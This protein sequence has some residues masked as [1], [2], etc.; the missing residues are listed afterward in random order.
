MNKEDIIN[1]VTSDIFYNNYCEMKCNYRDIHKDLYQFII[2]SLLEMKEKKLKAI[3]KGNLKGYVCRMIWLNATSKTAPFYKEYL[4]QNDIPIDMFDKEYKDE[5]IPKHHDSYVNHCKENHAD[6]LLSLEYEKQHEEYCRRLEIF[7]TK[8]EQN[9]KK[10]GYAV[11]NV[12]LLKLNVSGVS[13]RKIAKG[14]GI[15]YPSIRYTI[16]RLIDRINE[17]ITSYPE[18]T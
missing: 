8:E 10:K 16:K 5:Q 14:S 2:L 12:E 4:Q 13:L 9:F 3:N 17:D 7:I 6:C 1:K 15:P 11:L 18:G